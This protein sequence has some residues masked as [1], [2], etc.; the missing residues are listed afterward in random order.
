MPALPWSWRATPDP[1]AMYVV[2]FSK[3][4]LRRARH[5]PGFLV[6]T[7][8]IQRQRAN[9]NGLVA[10]ALNAQLARKTFWTVSASGGTPSWPAWTTEESSWNT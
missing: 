8:R 10:Y 2:M 5:I 1:D 7:R 4:P 6:D 3:L 9:T